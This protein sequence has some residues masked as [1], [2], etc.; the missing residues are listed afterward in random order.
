MVKGHIH[1][2]G[3]SEEPFSFDLTQLEPHKPVGGD[4]GAATWAVA[5]A[6]KLLS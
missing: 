4:I 2:V 1:L 3:E 5:L 6:K